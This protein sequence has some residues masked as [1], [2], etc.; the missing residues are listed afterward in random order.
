MALSRNGLRLAL[1]EYLQAA[2]GN[3]IKSFSLVDTGGE[4]IPQAKLPA[5][6]LRAEQSSGG[7]EEA[8]APPDWRLLFTAVV[9]TRGPANETDPDAELDAIATAIEVALERQPGEPLGAWW[10][11]LGGQVQRVYPTGT[12]YDAGLP[13]QLKVVGVGIALVAIPPAHGAP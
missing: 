3:T 12:V 11:T 8:L 10:T 13:G 5:L 6:I 7:S 9:Y 2:L 1:Y 4:T